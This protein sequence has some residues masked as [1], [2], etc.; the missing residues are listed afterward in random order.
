MRPLSD[1]RYAIRQLRKS[2]A[3]TVTVLL[4]LA[5]C[6]GAN[7]AI[8]SIVDQVFFRA[9]PY[10]DPGRL[11]MIARTFHK[12]NLR[13]VQS[14]LNGF[15]WQL[16]RDRAPSLESA[17][18]IAGS[19]GVN[20]FA[21]NH[22]EYLQKQEVCAGFFHVLGV[23][24]LMG[25]EFARQEDVPGGPNVAVL[26][27][28]T[29]QRTF[30]GDSGILGRSV[31]LQGAPYTVIGIMPRDFQTDAPQTQIWTSLQPFTT[32]IG[33]GTDY[34]ILGR[35]KP[36]ATVAQANGELAAISPDVGAQVHFEPGTFSLSIIP[37]QA[38][39]TM[40][41][42]S[43]V[44]LMWAAA[45][46]ILLIGCINIAGI[47]LAR[48]A[49]S[50]REIATRLALGGPRRAIIRQLLTEALTLAI[51]G[52]L[53]GLFLGSLVIKGLNHA[54]SNQLNLSQPLQLNME[55]FLAMAAVSILAG[56][57]FGL[58][59]AFEATT[60]DL[61]S[62]LAEAG[63]SSIGSRR[64]WKRQILVFAEVALGVVLVISTGL[65]LRS[66]S[67]LLNLNA[68]FDPNHVVTASLSLQDVRYKTSADA[69][70][71]F[72]ESLARMRQIPGV[73]SAG[74]TLTLPYQRALLW[75]VTI[76]G[77]PVRQ[78]NSMANFVYVTPGFFDALHISVLRGRLFSDRDRADTE[79]VTIVDQAFVNYHLAGT[80]DPLGKHVALDSSHNYTIVG[81]IHDIPQQQGWGAEYGPIADLPQMWIP[82]AQIPDPYFPLMHQFFSPSWV[83]RTHG[84]VP[85]L[86]QKMRQAILAVDP[87]LPFSA[88][89]TI[90]QVRSEALAKQRYQA[91]LFSAFAGLAM[92][93]CALG[94][95]GLIAQA[96][97]Q[98]RRE[99]GI[100]L[101]LGATTQNIIRTA[102]LPG[103]KL[104]IAGITCGVVLSL[105][106]TR[107]LKSLIWGVSTTDPTTFITVAA[108]LIAI[109]AIASL[110]PALRLV[111][112]DPAQTL[113]DE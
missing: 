52:G 107:L 72:R 6:I 104:S 1:L 85:N 64:Q 74:V 56:V 98:R 58:F 99:M 25:R 35:L 33:A 54:S 84:T 80:P 24:P 49:T 10:P 8:F 4:T 38:G 39:R 87:R 45:G 61:R 65:L 7:T 90:N 26:S 47:L 106:A 11:I 46:L 111:K 9:L 70:R 40:N 89:H 68:G 101:A 14:N 44:K 50:S 78:D 77:H 3:F 27:Y 32:G 12:G 88:F 93:L 28:A 53:L 102:V 21:N 51:G 109:A 105:L 43:N 81:I 69:T 42:R 71:L 96:V 60:V 82:A 41:V 17:V 103:I 63:R 20:L 13:A 108:L 22:V 110:L 83:V 19:N 66:L 36:G 113:R 57:V 95:Y 86:E 112:L 73:E 79:K 62:A 48:S 97:A 2:P 23:R 5:L 30:H 31:D 100:R 18:Y 59:P 75:G 34:Q 92:L 76:A 94:V 67:S 15:A 16:I 37:L 91:T 29:W 55:A